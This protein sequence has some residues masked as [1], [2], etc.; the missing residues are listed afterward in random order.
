MKIGTLCT[1]ICS[2]LLIVPSTALAQKPSSRGESIRVGQIIGDGKDGRAFAKWSYLT[3]GHP[4]VS[5]DVT[6][7]KRAGGKNAYLNLRFGKDKTLDNAKRAYLKDNSTQTFTWNIGGK[8]SRGRPLILN[9]YN[10]EV[11]V[12]SANVTYVVM[13]LL[14]QTKPPPSMAAGTPPMDNPAPKPETMNEETGNMDHC[15][16]SRIR[17]PRIEFGNF[18]SSGGLFSGKYRM[19]GSVFAACVEEAGYYENGRRVQSIDFP[20]SDRA[21]RVEFRVKV[22]TGRN[23]QIRVYQSNGHVESISVDDEIQRQEQQ[24]K[25]GAIGK[26]P[27]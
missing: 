11:E 27:F 22:R 3:K 9:A 18:K 25:G 16:H 2:L 24:N 26:L 7:R 6:V 5:I 8:R 15:R 12:I 17:Y 19:N 13:N 21:Q 4:I 14:D 23:G 20:R 10:G 1:L